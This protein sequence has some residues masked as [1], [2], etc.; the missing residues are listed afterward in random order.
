MSF[1]DRQ[2]QASAEVG[3]RRVGSGERPT[4]TLSRATGSGARS[5]AEKLAV[6]LQERDSDAPIP[7]AVFDKNLVH[8]VLEDH[9]LPQRLARYVPD[10][11]ISGIDYA[12]E[13]LLGLHPSMWTMIQHTIDTIL[14][15]ARMGNVILVGR[16]APVIAGK[17]KNAFHVRLVGSLEMRIAQVQEYYTLPH[18]QAREFVQRE[19]RQRKRFIKKY[20]GRDIEDSLLYYLTINTD[21]VF[22]DGFARIIGDAVLRRWSSDRGL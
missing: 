19:D 15:L 13:E 22:Y 1:I 18:K 7:W 9:H 10:E 17:F 12:V 3:F 4:I 8:K 14:A 20:F 6:Y 2:G 16:G 11:K 5:I 21:L